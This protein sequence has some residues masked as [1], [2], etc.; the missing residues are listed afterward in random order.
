MEKVAVLFPGQGAQ[1]VGMG[2]DLHDRYDYVREI[3]A[4]ADEILGFPIS[5]LCFEGPLEE[6]TKTNRSQP[7]I[8]VTS[9]AALE[10]AKRHGLFERIDVAAAAGL[11]LGEYTALVFAEALTFEDALRVVERR[12]TFMQQ[13]CDAAP[14]GMVSVIGLDFTTV[15]RLVEETRE[16]G[17]LVA[18]NYNSPLQVAVSGDVEALDRFEAAAAGAGA[19]RVVRLRVA[20]AFHSSLMTPAAERLA[21]F[22]DEAD[23]RAPRYPFLA[24]VTGDFCDDP[25]A[26]KE[27]LKAQVNHP[28]RWSQSIQRVA[29]AGVRTFWE[30]GPGTVLSSLVRRTVRDARTRNFISADS[31]EGD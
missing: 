15:E 25:V 13:A 29:D 28:V 1:K 23:V 16:D 21:P 19:K 20:G 30:I 11:S 9:V 6:L 2:K 12:G 4:K 27:N 22:I 7:A 18:A 3:Y 8:L 10:V 26:I 24:N 31:F 5:G 14:S 17:V